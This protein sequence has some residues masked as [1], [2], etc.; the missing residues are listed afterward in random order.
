MSLCNSPG[1]PGTHSVDQ[2]DLELK[3]SPCLCLPDAGIQGVPGSIVLKETISEGELSN[4]SLCQVQHIV[5]ATRE[6]KVKDHMCPR[7]SRLT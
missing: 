2:A 6:S 5:S 1:C 3:R 7:N 4:R